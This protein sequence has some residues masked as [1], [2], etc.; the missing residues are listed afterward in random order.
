VLGRNV[1]F[2]PSPVHAP[3][4]F[5]LLHGPTP[6]MSSTL[7]P[8]GRWPVAPGGASANVMWGRG[9]RVVSLI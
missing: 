7:S 4:S 1:D 8:R 6:L 9:V 2:G 5:S 3:Y